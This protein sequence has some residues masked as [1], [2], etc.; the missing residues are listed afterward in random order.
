MVAQRMAEED[1]S[2]LILD[3]Q[4]RPIGRVAHTEYELDRQPPGDTVYISR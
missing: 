3:D 4:G 2:Y 1:G